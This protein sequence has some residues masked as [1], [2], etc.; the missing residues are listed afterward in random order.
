MDLPGENSSSKRP[1]AIDIGSG[2]G[3]T[4]IALLICGFDVVC[5]DKS[6]VFD[7]MNENIRRFMSE[8]GSALPNM[9]NIEVIEFDWV[10]SSPA[11]L[12]N[13]IQNKFGKS[14]A[15]LILCSDCCYDINLMQPLVQAVRTV[16]EM[17]MS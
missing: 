1:L 6:H 9:G 10:I 13:V 11:D 15:D 4:A 3:L 16:S 7:L 8:N 5:T 17:S 14:C 2:C 12:V